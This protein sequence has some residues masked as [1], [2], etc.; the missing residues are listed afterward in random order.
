MFI[1]GVEMPDMSDTDEFIPL[2]MIVVVKG[3]TADGEIRYR[4]LTSNGL[5]PMERLGM[6]VSFADS[7][8]ALLM[9]GVRG[10]GDS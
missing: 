9:R 6:A 1:Y 2:D 4:E 3:F 5:S 7:M 8:R 10:T